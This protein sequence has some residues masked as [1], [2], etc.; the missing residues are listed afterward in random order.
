M[1]SLLELLPGDLTETLPLSPA[2]M[3]LGVIL[4]ILSTVYTL[5]SLSRR[6]SSSS[7]TQ[8][9]AEASKDSLEIKPLNGLDYKAVEPTKYRPF[10]PIF[11]I[12]M[13]LQ[14]DSP[15][16]LITVDSEYLD[17]VSLRRQIIAQH[18][19]M[20]HA[21]LPAGVEAV[22]ELHQYLLRDYLPTRFPTMFRL[23]DEG[24]QLNNLVTGRS[25]PTTTPDDAEA[26]LR[27]LGETVE[28]DMFLLME[29]PEGHRAVA[30]LCCFPSGFDPST[31]VG[32]LLKEIHS[33]VPSYDK[34]GPS[35]ERF[36]SKIEVGKSVKRTNWSMQT[37][38][39]L[40]HYDRHDQHKSDEP[41]AAEEIDMSKTY[42]RIELQTLTRLPKTRA[43]L[44]SFKTY[45]YPVEGIK[46][47]GLGPQV[48]DAIEGLKTGNAPG[49]WRYKGAPQWGE[50][51]CKYLRS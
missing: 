51:I 8:R 10:K 25:F 37:H 7:H 44:F 26:A 32:K 47:E 18:G 11:H 48:A 39:D 35:M 31:K 4:A 19:D 15:S 38:S 16:G 33:P 2:V 46:K 34:I 45:L 50:P 13:A 6:H 49:M 29:E 3:A 27:V 20:V 43:I 28:E 14:A 22:R 21:C 17:R 9:S 12:T 30:F 42:A 23:R 40:F 36:F 1:D 41:V 5:T 24:R